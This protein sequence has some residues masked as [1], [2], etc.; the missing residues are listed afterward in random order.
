MIG[1]MPMLPRATPAE[2]ANE[3]SAKA[4]PRMASV[5][6]RASSK[7]TGGSRKAAPTPVP[8]PAATS[9]GVVAGGS[10]NSRQT[11]VVAMPMSIERREPTRSTSRAAGMRA[12]T[13]DAAS[14]VKKSA[15]SA[16][17]SSAR[18]GR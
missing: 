11:A 5:E 2:K 6:R 10:R 4:E 1:L 13:S 15:M 18:W 7:L 17:A 14:A 16:P 3:K 8:M 12:I 9:N